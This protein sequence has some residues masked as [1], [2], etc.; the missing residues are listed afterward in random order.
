MCALRPFA[1]VR[2]GYD[3]EGPCIRLLSSAIL[4]STVVD[5]RAR[6]EQVAIYLRGLAA[7]PDVIVLTG[8]IIQGNAVAGY[9]V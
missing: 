3:Q 1:F 2:H 5:V 7:P 9:A 6:L 8:D 4:I